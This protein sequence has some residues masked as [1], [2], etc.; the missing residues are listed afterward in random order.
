MKE[1]KQRRHY[2]RQFQA[3]AVRLVTQS[4]QRTL[5]LDFSALMRRVFRVA[6]DR[7]GYVD[8]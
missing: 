2:D 8:E 1:K 3:E 5:V 6:L 4:G 7:V